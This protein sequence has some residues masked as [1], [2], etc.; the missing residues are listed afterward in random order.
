MKPV[1]EAFASTGFRR[2]VLPGIVLTV[3]VH[4]VL[5]TA[6][7]AIVSA[8]EISAIVLVVA[9]I[10]FFGLVVSSGLQW[11]YYLYEG[12]R[13]PLLTRLAQRVNERRLT[14]FTAKRKALYRGRTFD[15]LSSA[16]QEEV[17]RV[18]E[19]LCDFPLRR[20]ADGAVEHYVERPTRLG[21]IIATYELY[22]LSRYG[23]DGV[24]YWRHLLNLATDSSRKEFE[25]QYAFAE[26]LVLTS[27]SG[28]IV[29]LLHIFVLVGFLLGNQIAPVVTLPIGP[30]TSA[31]LALF[32]LVV[33][34]LFYRAS[35][36]AHREAA[37]AFRSIVDAVMTKFIE[38]M[39]TLK[40]PLDE[41]DRQH[42]EELTEYLK[43]LS[44]AGTA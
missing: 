33:W 2:V 32:G 4:P 30:S 36:P 15:Q 31:W 41:G 29:S 27:F 23:V 7:P 42:I 1:E 38:W 43:A 19:Y 26:N 14:Q 9:E 25:D 13:L 3:G 18:Y 40:A 20:H 11:V 16:E 28:A 6:M 22:P 8:Y 44:R 10:L 37:A 21:N 35:L 12:F 24:Y 17:T 34:L 5:S 39:R